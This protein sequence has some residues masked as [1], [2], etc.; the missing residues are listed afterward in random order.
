VSANSESLT[1]QLEKIIINMSDH[2]SRKGQDLPSVTLPKILNNS[3]WFAPMGLLSF[4]GDLGRHFR[5]SVMLSRDSVKSRLSSTQGI[6]FTE[7]SYQ[8]LQAFDFYHLYTTQGCAIQ[9][10]GSDQWGNMS[11]GL[12]FIKKKRDETL[13]SA[14]NKEKKD[15]VHPVGIT[16]PLVTTANGDKFG[17]SAGNAVWLDEKLTSPLDFY[18]VI[19]RF[20]NT[21]NI[22]RFENSSLG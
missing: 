17:K 22:S 5:V 15:A 16:L 11:A 21:K 1:Q 12:E 10:G 6:S 9:L 20:F 4:L 19:I 18:Q 8:I 2:V 13:Q 7:F 3:D 14:T